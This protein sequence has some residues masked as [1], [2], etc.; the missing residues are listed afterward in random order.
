MAA[1]GG[2]R[3]AAF[4]NAVSTAPCVLFCWIEPQPLQ[5]WVICGHLYSTIWKAHAWRR[6]VPVHE[7]DAPE[8]YATA[9]K[10]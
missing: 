10:L 4:S 8:P 7:L 1:E 5:P 3:R 6:R 2:G 9:R